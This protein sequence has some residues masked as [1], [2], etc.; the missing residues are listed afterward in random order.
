MATIVNG[1][2]IEIY[3]DFNFYLCALLT[4]VVITNSAI[5]AFFPF[6]CFS[7][8]SF[9]LSLFSC[10]FITI[11]IFRLIFTHSGF[12][13]RFQ[14]RTTNG[15][16][17][18]TLLSRCFHSFCLILSDTIARVLSFACV[19]WSFCMSVCPSPVH[20]RAVSFVNTV[21]VHK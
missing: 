8:W 11:I 13:V 15:I 2:M 17:K 9:F 4:D 1:L 3:W 12:C 5:I 20:V 14:M 18:T 16:H 10:D 19:F 7:A 21:H 6:V